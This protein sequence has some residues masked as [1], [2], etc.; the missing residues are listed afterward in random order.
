MQRNQLI[1]INFTLF[2]N[3]NQKYECTP[4]FFEKA[5]SYKPPDFKDKIALLFEFAGMNP[6]RFGDLFDFKDH[7][8]S[9]GW[10]VVSTV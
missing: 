3:Y 7:R 6:E 10:H 9:G 5:I 4:V 8:A 1:S 2:S